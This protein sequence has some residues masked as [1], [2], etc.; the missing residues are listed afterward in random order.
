VTPKENTMRGS[1]HHEL[2]G[3]PDTFAYRV[4]RRVVIHVNPNTPRGAALRAEIGAHADFIT[5]WIGSAKLNRC[6]AAIVRAYNEI[7]AEYAEQERAEASAKDNRAE[8]VADILDVIAD[9]EANGTPANP[10][11][12]GAGSMITIGDA[13]A[14]GTFDAI[15]LNLGDRSVFVSRGHAP[16]C[17]AFGDRAFHAR[18]DTEQLDRLSRLRNR[19]L[20]SGQR[21]RAVVGGR[22][23][24]VNF[25]H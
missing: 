12:P 24:R 11:H 22:N 13:D 23:L 6:H 1:I 10:R 8:I 7:E 25:V 16:G 15:R 21:Y 18:L 17:H 14:I 9:V 2:I 4:G 5:M 3:V 20:S 19:L